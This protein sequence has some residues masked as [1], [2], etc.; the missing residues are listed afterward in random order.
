MNGY[1]YGGLILGVVPWKFFLALAMLI[2]GT[3][4]VGC[5]VNVCWIR[6]R[7]NQSRKR[8]RSSDER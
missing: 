7:A 4:A 6:R 3:F 8:R 2:L 5:G 1:Y